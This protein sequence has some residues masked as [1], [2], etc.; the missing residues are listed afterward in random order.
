MW[1]TTLAYVI[2][3]M[4]FITFASGAMGVMFLTTHPSAPRPDSI[5][6]QAVLYSIL[7]PGRRHCGCILYRR[8]HARRN[9][10]ARVVSTAVC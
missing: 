2:A 10:Q 6:G 5:R 4:G 9:C 1:T 3:G 7:L 8:E